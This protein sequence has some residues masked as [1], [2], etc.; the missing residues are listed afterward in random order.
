MLTELVCRDIKQI[1]N[2]NSDVLCGYKYVP[3]LNDDVAIRKYWFGNRLVPYS[4]NNTL[5]Y[6]VKKT[7]SKM[8]YANRTIHT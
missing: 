1:H 4:I 2:N 7:R 8:K 5:D 6:I 3:F